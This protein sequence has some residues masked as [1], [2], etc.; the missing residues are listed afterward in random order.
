VLLIGGPVLAG[1]S[2]EAP[3]KRLEVLTELIGREYRLG[4]EKTAAG[5]THYVMV[6]RYLLDAK[7]IVR[8]VH[9]PRQW[10]EWVKSR[11]DLGLLPFRIRQAQ[12]YMRLALKEEFLRKT[13]PNALLTID[14]ACAIVAGPGPKRRSGK[15]RPFPLRSGSPN[16]PAPPHFVHVIRNLLQSWPTIVIEDYQPSREEI[17]ILDVD[18]PELLPA[19]VI[20]ADQHDIETGVR[21]ASNDLRD[22]EDQYIQAL[23]SENEQTQIASLKQILKELDLE[24]EML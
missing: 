10:Q 14:E 1:A 7:E 11:Y 2:E 18:L 23:L 19:L 15:K 3:D 6:G 13:H 21:L 12:N 8:K 24:A 4:N 16:R 17:A 9:G 22:I 5:L 20:L